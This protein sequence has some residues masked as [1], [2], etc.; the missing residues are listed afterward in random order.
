MRRD[1]KRGKLRVEVTL[2]PVVHQT[3]RIRRESPLSLNRSSTVSQ[4][5]QCRR[6]SLFLGLRVPAWTVLLKKLV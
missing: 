1:E 5:A 2:H 6:G 4:Q 3:K